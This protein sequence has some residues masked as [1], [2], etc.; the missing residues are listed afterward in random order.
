M[1][2]SNELTGAEMLRSSFVST[3]FSVFLMP[4]MDSWYIIILLVVGGHK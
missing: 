2:I 1:F 3:P 4:K